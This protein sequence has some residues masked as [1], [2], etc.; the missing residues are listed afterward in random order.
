M[1][2]YGAHIEKFRVRGGPLKS[3]EEDGRLWRPT[4]IDIPFPPKIFV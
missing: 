2:E 1:K 4:E 3:S